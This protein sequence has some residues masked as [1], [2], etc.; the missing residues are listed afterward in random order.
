MFGESVP[1]F[2]GTQLPLYSESELKS[3]RQGPAFWE[4]MVTGGVDTTIY[5]LPA[6]YPPPPEIKGRGT[7]RCL[8][9]M[10]TPDMLGGYGTFTSFRTDITRD[11]DVAVLTTSQLAV[12]IGNNRSREAEGVRHNAGYNGIFSITSAHHLQRVCCSMRSADR[13]PRSNHWHPKTCLRNSTT[14]TH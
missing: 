6:N 7:F 9:G 3:F 12:T 4:E 14:T 2:G 1:W 13:G 5:R 10:G 11:K 8:C